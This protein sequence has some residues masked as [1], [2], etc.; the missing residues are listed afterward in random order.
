[1]IYFLKGVLPWQNLKAVNKKEKYSKIMEKKIGT[2]VE[3]LCKGLPV[4]F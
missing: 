4:E 3:E 2:P 1:M